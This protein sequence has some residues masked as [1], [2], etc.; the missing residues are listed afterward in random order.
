MADYGITQAAIS[1]TFCVPFWRDTMERAEH[2]LYTAKEL[3]RDPRRLLVYATTMDAFLNDTD[4]LRQP[5]FLDHKGCWQALV[6]IHPTSAFLRD[7]V[8]LAPRVMEPAFAF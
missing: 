5:I 8:R 7:P 2:I 4:A 3:A 6:N 1:P